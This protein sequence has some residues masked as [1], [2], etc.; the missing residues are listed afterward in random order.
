MAAKVV[1]IQVVV[2][3]VMAAVARVEDC[4]DLDSQDM[5][6]AALAAAAVAWAMPEEAT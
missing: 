6:A 2:N 1:G 3:V 4:M 5:E